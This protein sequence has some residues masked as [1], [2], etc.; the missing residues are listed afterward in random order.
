MQRLLCL[1]LYLSTNQIPKI[2]STQATDLV[3]MDTH[4]VCG[5]ERFED[6]HPAGIHGPLEQSVSHLWDVHVG[7]VGG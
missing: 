3:A 5:D 6:D 7:L 2:L 4:V 1:V